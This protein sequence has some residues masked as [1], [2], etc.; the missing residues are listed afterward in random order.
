MRKEFDKL[1]NIFIL[2]KDIF[3]RKDINMSDKTTYIIKNL[4]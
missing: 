2:I 3:H 4:D 1:N